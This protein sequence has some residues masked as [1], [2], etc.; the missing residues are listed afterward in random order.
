M[1]G[2]KYLI[3]TYLLTALIVFYFYISSKKQVIS[4]YNAVFGFKDFFQ[5]L[6]KNSIASIWLLLSY[7]FGESII[8]IFFIING[9]VLGLLLSSFSSITYLLLVLPHGIIEI[10]T[11]V[12]LSDTIIN[13]RNNSQNKRKNVKRFIISFLLLTL[14]AGI[15]TFITPLMIN[16]IS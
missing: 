10:G 4:D 5:I 14:S 12:Y 6:L 13:M 9:I 1:R 2:K 3:L 7:V 8:Y 15:E 16:F 11:Y